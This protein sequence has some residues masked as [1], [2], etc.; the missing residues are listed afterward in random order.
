MFQRWKQSFFRFMYGRYGTDQLNNALLILGVVLTILGWFS[1]TAF[2]TV[3]SYI[4]LALVIFRMFSRDVNR[5]R[6]ENQKFLQFFNRLKDRDSRY[7]SCPRCRQ[8][9]R[10]PRHR[11]KINIHCPKCGN[12]FIKKT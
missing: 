5:R 3:L 9:V 4:P 7:F 8:T 2:L 1:S 6:K 12:R 11:G 10:V